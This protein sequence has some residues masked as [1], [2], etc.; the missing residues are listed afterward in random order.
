[1][2]NF[3]NT[4]LSTIGSLV[5][6]I[7]FAYGFYQNSMRKRIQSLNRIRAWEF[8]RVMYS[9]FAHLQ[10]YYTRKQ[11]LPPRNPDLDGAMA[12]MS[13]LYPQA[14]ENILA[15]YENITPATIDE[16]QHRNQVPES[17]VALFKIKLHDQEF[18]APNKKPGTKKAG[19]RKVATD[20]GK[21]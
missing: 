5:G 2:F 13:V 10:D 21:D 8:F 3:L 17:A 4:I 16:W 19:P 15:Q 20:R 14:I 6:I 7:G 18:G 11:P 1:M 12:K 9:T